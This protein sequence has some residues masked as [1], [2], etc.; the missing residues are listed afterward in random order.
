MG[1]IHQRI[2]REMELA[3]RVAL[4]QRLAIALPDQPRRVAPTRPRYCANCA[5]SLEFGAVLSGGRAYCS[6][7]CSLGSRTA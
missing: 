7:E 4:R 2:E 3:Q 5:E 6:V 1:S